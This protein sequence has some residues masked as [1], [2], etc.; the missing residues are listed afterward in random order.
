M[1]LRTLTRTAATA[2]AT[3]AILAAP[4]LALAPAAGATPVYTTYPS[5]TACANAGK[6]L[7]EAYPGLRTSCLM[8]AGTADGQTELK[9]DPADIPKLKSN[10]Q[11]TPPAFGG[12]FGS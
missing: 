3:A 6:A 8:K 2:L 12:F 1:N 7:R 5:S 9:Y 10:P 11:P 4:A